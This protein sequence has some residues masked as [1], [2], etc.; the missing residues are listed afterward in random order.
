MDIYGEIMIS[1]VKNFRLVV[2][3][4]LVTCLL[5]VHIAKA[6]DWIYTTVKGD[7]LWNVSE[8]HLD[9]VTRYLQL[10]KING[11]KNPYHMQPGTQIRIPMKWI[12]NNSV[13]AEILSVQGN[14]ELLLANGN[15]LYKLSPGTL[16]HLG[17]HL[18]SGND[19]SV[20]VKFADNSILTLHSD[21]SIRFDHLS[22]HGVT[23]MVDSRLHLLEGRMDTRVIPASGPGSRFEIKTPS[24]ISAVRGTEYRALVIPESQSSNIEV[25]KGKVLVT[26]AQKKKLINAGF[27][28]QVVKG[29][30]PIAP[31]KLLEPPVFNNIDEIL[32]SIHFLVSWEPVDGA[33]QYRIEL[34]AN[35]HFNTIIWQE[36]SEYTRAA[37]PDLPDG[38]YSIR[39]RGVDK[40][41]LEGKSAI[42][43]IRIDARPQAPVQ[44]KPVENFIIRGKVPELQWTAS[45]EADR[46][47]IEIASDA[48]FK[49]QLLKR[50]DIDTTHFTASELAATGKYYWRITSIAANGEVG[51]AGAIRSYEIKSIPDKVEPEMETADD[52]RFVATWRSGAPEQSYQV[53]LA[54]DQMFKDLEFDKNINEPLLSFEPVSGAIRYLR[55]RAIEPDGYQGPWGATQRVDP[56]ADDT[57]WWVPVIGLI[58]IIIL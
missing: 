53:Q 23:G 50:V 42:Q 29:K 24:A 13:P 54:Y 3:C 37:L 18:K 33:V 8:R 25:L 51:P 34:A 11:I 16:I 5:Q 7:S 10:K 2:L 15:F 32:R 26:G 48:E 44:L 45:S 9:K 1:Y 46:Y 57:A 31:R 35:N 22:A 4:V 6:E 14:A 41:G 19:S 21:S 27:G 58:G 52:G 17:D 28:T 47:K 55:I 39:V 43:A 12:K 56:L 36:F 40:S 38:A 30:P 20:A 49:Q